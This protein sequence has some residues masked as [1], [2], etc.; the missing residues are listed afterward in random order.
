MCFPS[1]DTRRLRPVA[2]KL[3]ALVNNYSPSNSPAAQETRRT[4]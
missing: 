4:P 1:L 2:R 3:V